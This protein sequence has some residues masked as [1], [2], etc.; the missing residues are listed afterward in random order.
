MDTNEK[1]GDAP[2][3]GAVDMSAMMASSVVQALQNSQGGMMDVGLT[4][5]ALSKASA[6][7][8]GSMSDKGAR[9]ALVQK[10]G[11]QVGLDTAEVAAM[12]AARPEED[13]PVTVDVNALGGLN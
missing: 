12:I 5:A 1:Q 10:Y 3:I 2:T 13:R 8:L 7:V 4:L 9:L 11:L 6:M